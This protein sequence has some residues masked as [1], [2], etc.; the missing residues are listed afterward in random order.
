MISVAFINCTSTN[1]KK[2]KVEKSEIE[3]K[4]ITFLDEWHIAASV[5]NYNNYFGKMD[6]ISV[7]IG[8]DAG[9]NWTKLSLK[10]LANLILMMVKHGALMMKEDKLTLKHYVLSVTVPNDDIKKLIII[11]KKKILCTRKNLLLRNNFLY[12]ILNQV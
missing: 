10:V 3:K 11:K 1:S 12:S 7:F 2:Q 5:A 4:A 9:E 6:S 8:T